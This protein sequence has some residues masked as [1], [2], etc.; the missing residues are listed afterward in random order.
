M[1]PV[2]AAGPGHRGAVPPVAMDRA[3][4][5]GVDVV[6]DGSAIRPRGVP[7]DP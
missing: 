7:A 4:R 1:L 5:A 2:P 3:D 6:D